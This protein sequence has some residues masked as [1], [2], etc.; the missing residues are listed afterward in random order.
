MMRIEMTRNRGSRALVFVHIPKAAGSTLRAILRRQF[1]REETY[2]VP[3][4]AAFDLTAEQREPIRLLMGHVP[5]GAHE[6]LPVRSDSITMLRDPIDRVASLYY[7]SLGRQ[8]ALRDFIGGM[9]LAEFGRSEH[10]QVRNDQTRLLSGLP[11]GAPDAV[12]LETAKEN[13]RSRFA[14]FG[15]HNRFDESVLLFARRFAWRSVYY[16]MQNVTPERPSLR[17]IDPDALHAIEQQNRLDRQL[18]TF[19]CELFDERVAALGESF[20]TEVRRFRRRNAM[21]SRLSAAAHRCAA[22]LPD[23][24]RTLVRRGVNHLSTR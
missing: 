21:Y 20:A 4:G 2:E 8:N 10:A 3:P 16:R 22:P 11:D 14:A 12:R 9:S 17:E 18:Y 1:S 5:Y 15:L 7:Y 24:L 13:L 23:A 6:L 19:A